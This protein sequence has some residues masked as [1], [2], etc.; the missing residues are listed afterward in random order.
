MNYIG[1]IMIAMPFILIFT[2]IGVQDGFENA[3]RVAALLIVISA[4]ICTAIYLTD[5]N[6]VTTAFWG[7]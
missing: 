7:E 6:G 4:Y 1:Y 5:P 2:V 3:C